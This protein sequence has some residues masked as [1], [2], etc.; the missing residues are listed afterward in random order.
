M[1]TILIRFAI[2]VGL[3]VLTYFGFIEGLD[4][5]RNVVQFFMWALCFTIGPLCLHPDVQKKLADMPATGPLNRLVYRGAALFC[6][7]V[8]VWAG[9][10]FTAMAWSFYLLC[11]L[12]A[13][14]QIKKLRT[15][16]Q[17]Q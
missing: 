12:I 7:G 14:A 6:L 17:P 9:Y 13:A 8:V 1:Q 16:E 11:G 15:K 3:P 5:A 10:I 4:G 2:L